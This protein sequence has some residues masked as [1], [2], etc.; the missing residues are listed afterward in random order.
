MYHG[1]FS[2]MFGATGSPRKSVLFLQ[3]TICTPLKGIWYDQDH[4]LLQGF[5][6]LACSVLKHEGALRIMSY[7]PL[8][9]QVTSLLESPRLFEVQG[10]YLGFPSLRQVPCCG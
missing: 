9:E 2:V 1:R 5:S 4:R 7:C 8:L 6:S 10:F 3:S